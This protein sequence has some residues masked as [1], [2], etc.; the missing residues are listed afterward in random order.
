[1]A[2][3]HNLQVSLNKKYQSIFNDIS[4]GFEQL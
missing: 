3:G 1:M 4:G 2:I